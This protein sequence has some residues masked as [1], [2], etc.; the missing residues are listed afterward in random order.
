M[1]GEIRL[2][3]PVE[4][5]GPLGPAALQGARQRAV[6]GALALHPGQVVSQDRLVDVLWD[7]DPPRTAVKSLH[8]HVARVRQVLGECGLPG[9]LLTREPGYVLTIDADMVDA[10]RFEQTVV[11]AKQDLS[12][13]T[14]ADRLRAALAL[15]RGDALADTGFAGWGVAEINRLHELRLAAWE[16]LW[17]AELR[18]GN[19]SEA[20]TDLERL[21]VKY[22]T[23]ERLVAL[24]MRALYRCGRH[25][26]ALDAYQ[27]LRDRLDDELGVDPGPELNG[28]YTDILRRS[29]ALGS[30]Q[31]A[32]NTAAPAQLPARVGYFVGRDAQLEALDEVLAD[33][34]DR[35]VIVIS[36]AA[37]MGKTALAVQWA[38]QAASRF[39]DGQLFLDLRGHDPDTAISTTDALTHL[40]LG[41]GVP[42]DRIPAGLVDKASLY[43]SLLHDRRILV[44]LDNCGVTDDI[45]PL[46]PGSATGLLLITSRNTLAP[47]V[48]RHAVQVIGLDALAHNEAVRLLGRVLGAARVEREPVPAA[49]LVRL[50]G[51]MPLALRIATAKLLMRPDRPIRDLVDELASADRLDSLAVPGDSLSVRTVFASAYRSLSEPTARA[52]RMLG[53]HPGASFC[54]H[55]VAAACGVPAAG[56]KPRVAELAASHLVNEVGGARYRLHDLIK[57]FAHQCALVDESGAERAAAGVRIVDWYL[58]LAGVELSSVE[59]PRFAD[60]NAAFDFLDTERHNMVAVVQFANDNG[61]HAAAWQLTSALTAFFN[62]RGHWTER[63]E[64]C[65]VGVAAAAELDDPAA[66]G[67]ALRSLGTAYRLAHRMIEALACYPRA[68]EL[69]RA[70]GDK[71]GE[72]AVYNNIGGAHV[73]LRRF[74]EA[75]NAYQQAI[76]LQTAAGNTRGMALAQRNLGYTYVCVRR[77]ELSFDLLQPALAHA[78]S[79]GDTWL[80]AGTL[81]SLGEAFRLQGE[82]GPALEHFREALAIARRTGD[83]RFESES[84]NNIGITLLDQGDPDAALEN[85]NQALAASQ[86]LADLHL[87]SLTRGNIGRARLAVGDLAG[88][89]EQL[90]HALAIRERVPDDYAEAL[91]HSDLADLEDRSGQP[92]TAARHRLLSA[93]LDN[94]TTAS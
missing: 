69:M 8:S 59:V 49:H 37:G 17:D 57:V 92:D 66:E 78:R 90:R 67:E 84:F 42:D 55:L 46:V 18:R 73:Q 3:G 29:P 85:L 71:S 11:T 7:D 47:L 36:G 30:P 28:L 20:V 83:R 23:R 70:A 64:M 63:I 60:Q 77:P 54:V 79:L 43:R 12:G 58:A 44:V 75:V 5:I 61:L 56:A 31:V 26:D 10:H 91:L 80:E 48:V 45:L 25:V 27:R 76:D 65:K 93:R 21:L 15:W 50:C 72:A 14:V 1:R 40:L 89:R 35:P 82:L 74:D 88:A 41:L 34:G 53:V 39:P 38:H 94:S 33:A 32:T 81:D 9:V 87:E 22:P 86:E 2:L 51:G 24:Y 6:V 13:N 52:F 16:C 4:V 68:L 19:H 62:A